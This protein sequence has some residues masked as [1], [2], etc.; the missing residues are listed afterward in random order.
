MWGILY[1]IGGS[2]MK[3][4]KR[5][6]HT[7]RY[8]EILNAFFKNGFSHVLH[9]LGLTEQRKKGDEEIEFQGNTNLH[10]VG[11]KLRR[12]LQE[13]GPTFIKLGQMI[14]SRRDQVPKEV[15]LELAKLQDDVESIPYAEVERILEFELGDSLDTLYQSF[16]KEPIASASIGQVH[17]ATLH[18]GIEVAVKVQRP[19][20]KSRVETDLEI[21]RDLASL[22]ESRIK[23]ARTYQIVDR[24]EEFATSLKEEL[25]YENEGRNA[26][27]IRKQF[28]EQPDIYIPAIYW[29]HTTD[30]V[31]TMEAIHGIKITN[32]AEL[33]AK[34]YDRQKIAALLA[35]SIF[36]QVLTHGFFHGDPHPGNLFVLP[37]D[38]ISYIDFGMVGKLGKQMR[39]HFTSLLLYVESGNSRGIIKTFRKM[40][41]LPT[42]QDADLLE[43]DLQD[44]IEQYYDAT[45][46][47]ISLGQVIVEIFQIAYKHEVTIPTDITILAKVI[48]TLEDV[49]DRLDPDFSIMKAVEPFGKKL[50]KE[51]YNPKNMAKD[52]WEMFSEN[53]EHIAELPRD[54]ND[55]AKTL[56][57]GKLQFDINIRDLTASLRRLDRISNR[58]SFSIILLAFSILMAGLVIGSAIAGQT[59][60]LMKLPVIEF[61][62]VIATLMF[63]LMLYTIIRSG[64][65]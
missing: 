20:I 64:R 48:L 56:K 36:H 40:G 13:L 62:F 14:S 37:N 16:E 54:I 41:I 51:R 35:D 29:T 15:A 17:M 65:M 43:G 24:F 28:V 2:G 21:I 26:E 18:S 30:K 57:R 8:R 49:I 38:A 42:G 23:W 6:R 45:L 47:T 1:R 58:L 3:I 60:I 50:I 7:M 4:G 61:G 34:G 27:R 11:V 19:D 46:T 39:Y 59:T 9:R 33:D 44:L 10:D 5:L 31:L 22:M 12:A 55:I 32:I 25:D 52:T 63:L 53:A